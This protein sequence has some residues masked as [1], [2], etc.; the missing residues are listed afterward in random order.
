MAAAGSKFAACVTE[1]GS[2]WTWG[3]NLY[4][5]LAVHTYDMA[6]LSVPQHIAPRHFGKSRAAMVACGSDFTLVLTEAGQVWTS[7]SNSCGVL[8]HNDAANCRKK[9]TL[10]QFDAKYFG[11]VAV[12]MVAAGAAHCIAASGDAHRAVWT[13]G[14]NICGQLGLGTMDDAPVPV[15]VSNTAFGDGVVETV[16]AC[17]DYTMVVT[18]IGELFSCGNGSGGEL[19]L[20]NL[21]SY[22]SFQQVGGPNG[23]LFGPRGVRTVVCS[24][25][26]T[27]ILARNKTV[28]SCGNGSAPCLGTTDEHGP[29]ILRPTQIPRVLMH[30]REVVAIGAGEQHSAVVTAEGRV[31]EW[32]QGRRFQQYAMGLGDGTTLPRWRP[33]PLTLGRSLAVRAGRWHKTHP[34]DI[35]A[36]A[37]ATHFRVGA[38]CGAL[39]HFPAEL[40]RLIASHVDYEPRGENGRGF[41]AMVGFD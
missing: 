6:G 5:Q 39:H 33:Y 23:I 20:G 28:W 30:N 4:G 41:L 38:K 9:H 21:L 17:Y 16:H 1:D 11:N 36:F 37:M 22:S 8:G 10:T 40:V 32:G 34:R 14:Q 35:T 25:M 29:D 18:G 7:G 31:Y 2:V 19:G 3:S 15:M 26:H 24:A 12:K 27:L 13:W